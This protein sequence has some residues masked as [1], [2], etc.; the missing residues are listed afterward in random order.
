MQ[1]CSDG[2]WK[3]VSDFDKFY[4]LSYFR[5]DGKVTQTIIDGNISCS[6]YV[7]IELPLKLICVVPRKKMIDNAYTE[8]SIASIINN[9]LILNSATLKTSL[10][11]RKASIMVD[12][13]DTN[14]STILGEEYD[15]VKITDLS[16]S[17]AYV[18][19]SVKVNI[20]IDLSCIENEC[21]DPDT[22]TSLLNALTTAEKLECILPTYDFSDGV[23]RDN[24]TA[25]QERDL[26]AAFCGACADA[27]V[28][29]NG[30][31]YSVV[32]SGGTLNI[33]VV[34]TA[35]A[36]VGTNTPGVSVEIQ[37]TTVTIKNSAA[38]TLYTVTSKAEEDKTQVLADKTLTDT[39]STT[40][41]L[42]QGLDYSCTL[43][44]NL[45]CA[46]LNSKLTQ[47]QRQTINQVNPLKTGQ[48]TSYRTGDDGD[49]EA[50]RLTSF[51]VLPCN[52]SFGN[53]DRFTD[54]VGGQ[55]YGAGN[56]S[57]ADYVIDHATGLGW[58]RLMQGTSDWDNSIDDSLSCLLYTS[59]SPRDRS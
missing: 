34:D 48:T 6:K 35:A 28:N 36:A 16:F 26:I 55:V 18:S 8:D 27:T 17:Y 41:A 22:C 24:L 51:L 33:P 30:V 40:S 43:I 31:L 7:N 19:L 44:E 5:K 39:D 13:Y 4:G 1:Y 38:T 37:D 14:G 21:D 29:I 3:Q 45:S 20:E 46:Q 25:L 12:D 49:L 23:V 53:T 59:P 2:E 56:G 57:L 42:V 58:Y 50:G 10:G 32:A 47:A 52:N 11:A 54:S 15:N 9:Q